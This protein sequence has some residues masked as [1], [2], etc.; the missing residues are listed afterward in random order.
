MALCR[1]ANIKK[2]K[3]WENANFTFLILRKGAKSGILLIQQ[4]KY[5]NIQ[6]VFPEENAKNQPKNVKKFKHFPSYPGD[7]VT[8]TE[9]QVIQSVTWRL[10]DNQGELVWMFHE[11]WVFR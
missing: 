5:L 2:F 10:P 8:C 9:D 6:N 11:H 1:D 3:I 4:M 7:L